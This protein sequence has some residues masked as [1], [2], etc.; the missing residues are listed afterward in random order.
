MKRNFCVNKN[1]IPFCAIGPDH[2][3][4]HVNK[5]MKFRGGLKGLTQQPAAMAI[6]FLIAPELSRLSAEAEAMVGIKTHNLTHHHDLSEAVI[7]RYEENVKKLKEVFKANDP[8]DN[9]ETEL[10]NI[11]TKAVMPDTVKEALLKRDEIGQEHFDKFVKERI[12]E[13]ELS[14]WSPMKEVQLQTWRSI[15]GT[16]KSK[17]ASSVAALK[18]DRALFARFLVVVHSRPD[19]DLKE[20]ISE[21]ELASFPRTLFNSGDLRLC[22]GKSKL[23][24]ILENLLPQQ[25]PNGEEK[26]HQYAGSVVIIDGMAV[27]QSMGKPTCVRNGRDLATHFLKIVDK[28][29][30]N[31]TKSMSFLIA[32]TFQTLSKRELAGIVKEAAGPWCTISQMTLSLKRFCSSS[33]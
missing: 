5:I 24:N 10:L 25:L 27:V 23:M 3:I 29:Q 16:K 6:W 12:V 11:I 33:C 31:I 7:I 32:M 2:A 1:D 20:S 28:G 4:E 14:V 26:Q 22:V 13:R 8:L 30:R 18:Y 9:E 19:I 17:T 21:F 15:R